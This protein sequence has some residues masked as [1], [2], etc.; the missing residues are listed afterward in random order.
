[1]RGSPA[2]AGAAEAAPSFRLPGEHFAAALAFL[3]L[4]ALGLVWAGPAAA[5]GGYASPRVAAVVHL[6][7]LGW[8]TTSIMG[9]L[10]Q[11]LPVA[12]GAP[13]R[14]ETLGHVAFLLYVPGVAALVAGLALGISGLAPAGAGLAALGLAVFLANLAATLLR[15][16]R[17]RFTRWTVAAAGLFLAATVT[18]GVL[19][20]VNLRSG[21]L[22]GGRFLV[23]GLHVHVAAGGWVLLVVIGV[24]DRLMP[25][26]LLSHGAP[27][28]PGRAAAALVAGGAAVLASV[29]HLLPVSAVPVGG[30]LL[31]AGTAAFLVQSALHY[32]ASR[33]PELDPGMR[34][35]AV[36]LGFLALALLLGPPAML[37][38]PAA[39]R[40]AAGYGAS[41]VVGGLGLFVAG[42]YYR[43]LPFLVWFHRF[44][45]VAADR[46][47]PRVSELFD[48]RWAAAATL[49][50]GAGAAG[51]VGALLAGSPAGARLGGL[52]LA[53]GTTVVTAQMAGIARRRPDP[54][55]SARGPDPA[56]RRASGPGASGTERGRP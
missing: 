11:L 56:G 17:G 12:L 8:I 27:E 44:G 51:L 50:L 38:A 15:A 24:A 13:V 26:F 22:G 46:D 40:M 34:L 33:K 36:G 7:T 41:L 16:E 47:V 55:G 28:W 32:R 25:M 4:G 10:Y 21:L 35:A 9:A 43:I 2:A 42:H 54:A 53:V 6:F 29:G 19:L 18:L 3:V 5:G 20:A 39:P 31:A 30:G 52:S 1:M 23:L 49:L 48:H 37:R 45:P 14:S